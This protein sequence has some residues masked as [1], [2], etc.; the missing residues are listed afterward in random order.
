MPELVNM[1]KMSVY[2][3]YTAAALA[4]V[5]CVCA[6]PSC[7]KPDETPVT[8]TG[9]QIGADTAD[10]SGYSIVYGGFSAASIRLGAEKLAKEL[11]IKAYADKDASGDHPDIGDR[12]ILLGSTDREASASALEE[13]KKS[14][15]KK[16]GYEIKVSGKKITIVG[17]NVEA[18]TEGIKRFMEKVSST[19]D[20]RKTLAMKD[21]EN[22]IG[23]YEMIVAASNGTRL[24]TVFTSDIY[25]PQS[26]SW[27][28]GC[29]YPTVIELQHQPDESKNGMLYATQEGYFRP[30]CFRIYRSD[31]GGKKWTKVSQ[32][33][34]TID[35]TIDGYEQPHLFELPEKVGDMPA[36]TLILGGT[37]IDGPH[38]RKSQISL[39]RSYNLGKTWEQFT[40][41]ATGGGIGEGVWEPFLTYEDGWLYC[42]FSDDSDPKHDQKL[43]YRRTQDGVT[44]SE[45]VDVVA[46]G[47]FDDRPG[48]ISIAKM[49][50]GKYFAV[51]EFVN[52]GGK[53]GNQVFYK[54][55]DSIS[56]WDTASTGTALRTKGE[57]TYYGGAPWCAWTPAGGECGTL[58]I[59]TWVG[60]ESK[61]ILSFDYGETFESIDSPLTYPETGT[62][63][64]QKFGYSPSLFFSADGKTLYY[65]NCIQ[66]KKYEGKDNFCR[67]TLAKMEI[68]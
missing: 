50:N 11:G 40:I 35:T 21:G 33:Q 47:N 32:V 8:T 62:Y 6:L 18:T 52:Y 5:I 20:G 3:K 24:K 15:Q 61:M 26:G 42:F 4:A 10:L 51:Y 9:A 29:E 27:S 43:S 31:D 60:C 41:V 12:E 66:Y 37:S 30:F 7:K 53:S 55:S 56:E 34:E 49:G 19:G 57:K 28:V 67:I 65:A 14:T 13:L 58:V 17:T 25:R 59:V 23:G 2:L 45:Q 54:T 36:G 46:C 63:A 48:M 44:W 16:Y 22:V 68:E 64:K 39:W 38:E 1:K